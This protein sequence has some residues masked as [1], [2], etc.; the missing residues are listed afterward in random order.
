MDRISLWSFKMHRIMKKS[1]FYLSAFIAAAATLFS[2]A[3]TEEDAIKETIEPKGVPFEVTA[4]AEETKTTMDNKA[5]SWEAGDQIHLFHAENESTTYVNDGAFTA[6]SAGASTA[7]TGNLDGELT[8]EKYDWYAVYPKGDNVNTPDMYDYITIGAIPPAVQTQ[9]GENDMTHLSGAAFPLWGKKAA[10]AKATKPAFSFKPFAS[11]V[12][13]VV[14]NKIAEDITVQKVTFTSS[15]ASD[16][17]GQYRVDFTGDAPVFTNAAGSSVAELEVSGDGAFSTEE[18]HAFYI[19]VKPFTAT[20]GST[21]TLTVQT[22]QGTQTIQSSALASDFVFRAGKIHTLNFNFTDRSLSQATFKFND[23]DWL[24]AQGITK[25]AANKGTD[26]SG[27]PI[28]EDPVTFSTVSGSTAS[29]V[30]LNAAGTDYD[31]RAYNGGSFTL[32]T[33]GSYVINKI[34]FNGSNL[35]S[36]RMAPDCGTYNETNKAWTGLAQDVTFD[37]TGTVNI[38]TITV[39]YSVAKATD[40]L[41]SVSTNDIDVA[42]DETAASFTVKKLNVDDLTVTASA[43]ATAT[44]VGNTVNVSF[45]AN[46]TFAAKVYTITVK[47]EANSLNET[48]TITQAPKPCTVSALTEG[49]LATVDGQVAA[50]TTNGFMLADA[51]GA[52]FVYKSGTGVALG[53]NVTVE[54]TV[55]SYSKGLQFPGACT[56]TKGAAGTYAYP[57]PAAYTVT[58]IDTW[59]S[60]DSNRLASYVTFTGVVKKNGSNYDIIVGGGATANTTI[61]SAPATITS[62]LAE[63]DNVT[64]TGYAINVMS[65]RMGVVVKDVV[66]S[67]TTP[68]IVFSDI[69]DVPAAGVTN[70][71]LTVSPFRIAGWTPNVTFTGCVS[72]AS[73]NAE[74]TTVTYSV[75]NNPDATTKNGTIVVTFSNGVDPDVVYT[76]N[77]SQQAKVS[78]T[79]VTLNIGTYA[80]AN[81]WGNGTKYTSVTIDSNVTATVSGGTNSGKYYTD[82]N[83]WRLYQGENATI[84]INAGTKTIT[85]VVVNYNIKNT[86]ILK[87]ASDNTV[88]SGDTYAVGTS[89]VTFS[90]KNSGSATNGQVKI[91]S[92]RVIYN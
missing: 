40:H 31:F 58:E 21:I 11:V 14:T 34:D 83:E 29:R 6:A 63:G 88:V 56:V 46:D 9:T 1:I 57:S 68:K 65:G 70:A 79:D 85:S 18:S 73:I 42:Y 27:T 71:T 81:S 19:A 4:V 17:V 32:S 36:A 7:F 44:L 49:A 48:V 78:G 24:D 28:T 43:G 64:V 45:A 69:T 72:A 77:V 39:F 2:C 26:I 22:D 74:C 8:A 87:D 30:F 82:G 52:I 61:Y 59:N 25:P 86:G 37:L 10:V 75:S 13:V 76:I 16:L 91:T 62:G 80:T 20:A 55:G 3:K 60:N 51:T 47:S 33:T 84:T 50:I 66:N 92:I 90:V 54:G 67:E 38:K 12:K 35:T 89:S 23:P 5:I 15:A 53:Q 41:L